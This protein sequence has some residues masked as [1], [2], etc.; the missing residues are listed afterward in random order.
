MID[1][2][3]NYGLIIGVISG[4]IGIFALLDKK[5]AIAIISSAFLLTIIIA[6]FK[7]IPFKYILNVDSTPKPT[8]APS[9]SVN[10]TGTEWNN[11]VLVKGN[12]FQMGSPGNELGR[13]EDEIQHSVQLDDFY[14][15][16][17]EITV[18]EFEIFA[19][20]KKDYKTEAD[21]R[22][23]CQIFDFNE[24]KWKK[25]LG[26]N[27]RYNVNGGEQTD[28]SQPVIF[29]GWDD[30]NEYCK[31]LSKK[32]GRE[33]RLPTE[34]EWE[35]ACRAGTDTPFNMGMDLSTKQANYK[36]DSFV[37]NT[38]P[39]G[40]YIPNKFGLYDMH[41]NAYE[42]CNDWYNSKYY[43]ECKINGTKKNPKGPEKGTYHVLRGGSWRSQEK[44][45][46]SA[47][48]PGDPTNDSNLPISYASFRPVILP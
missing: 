34:A 38:M 9:N 43:D 32:K 3:S 6:V 42:W 22:G 17:Y 20:D 7:Y 40:S 37:K 29:V 35:Y 46:R 26:I 33:V 18:K 39:V 11:Y 47:D 19:A 44:S 23:F 10:P 4:V 12:T 48:R 30:A 28:K 36:G 14:I 1:F 24:N 21:A 25:I 41:G 5:K 2:L 16:K 8:L 31:W 45:C 27:W 13:E 15:S